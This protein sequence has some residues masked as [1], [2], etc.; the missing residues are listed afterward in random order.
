MYRYD[1]ES[2]TMKLTRLHSF[3]STDIPL[4]F[5]NYTAGFFNSLRDNAFQTAFKS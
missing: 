3:H 1:Y 4:V 5:G 2:P